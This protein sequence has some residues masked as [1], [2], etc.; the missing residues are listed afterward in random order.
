MPRD[1]LLRL[2]SHQKQPQPNILIGLI[3]G[4]D[5]DKYISKIGGGGLSAGVL[6]VYNAN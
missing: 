4:S 2:V 3:F 6:T 5:S 1:P